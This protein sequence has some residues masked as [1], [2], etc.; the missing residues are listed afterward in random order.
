MSQAEESS[1]IPEQPTDAPSEP[2]SPETPSAAEP[3]AEGPYKLTTWVQ[4]GT[5]SSRFD[6]QLAEQVADAKARRAEYDAENKLGAI[7]IEHG[8]A[9]LYA[10]QF[11]DP[12]ASPKVALYY[13][14][15]DGRAIT[16]LCELVTDD[17]TGEKILIFVC[18]ECVARGVNQGFAQCRVSDKNRAWHIDEKGAGEVRWAENPTVPG[19]RE[20]Y[21]SAGTIMDTDALRC[22]GV[23][24][25][26]TFKVHKNR[27]YRTR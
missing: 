3:P 5:T 25:G 16:E 9:A 13:E 15:R 6:T 11:A 23:G 10:H 21:R 19:G 2:A 7:P 14:Y 12:V 24:C 22:A 17:I 18:P 27:L 8:G 20:F 26:C 4:G 1:C